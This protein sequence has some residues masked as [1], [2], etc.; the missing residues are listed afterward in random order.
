MLGYHAGKSVWRLMSPNLNH[1]RFLITQG[2]T[3]Y[4]LDRWPF[5][6]DI[7]I[8]IVRKQLS[9]TAFNCCIRVAGVRMRTEVVSKGD[10][11]T[12]CVIAVNNHVQM[13]SCQFRRMLEGFAAGNSKISIMNVSHRN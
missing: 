3:Q 2:K 8:D 11:G 12:M 10:I 4:T 7:S 1:P 6:R 9:C 5:Y 13:M